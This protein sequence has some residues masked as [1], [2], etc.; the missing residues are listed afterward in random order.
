[1][2][3]KAITIAAG[4]ACASVA[5]V[6]AGTGTSAPTK[7]AAGPTGA[8]CSNPIQIGMEGPF[9]GPVA[10]IGDDQLHWA[11]FFATEWNK[12]HTVKINIV[13][14][15]TQLTPALASTV[16]QSFASNSSIVGVIGPAGSQEVSAA[17]P[18]LKKAGLA[19]ISG[20]ATNP[21]LT[22]GQYTGYFF[23]VVPNDSVQ[24][25]SDADFMMKNL[26]VKKGSTVMVVDDQES[27][28]TGLADIVG[29]K[30]KA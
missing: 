12:T 9:T 20:S 10:S 13:Q 3:R 23:R 2:V 18:I 6:L 5:L 16:S 4:S 29:K 17:A 30:L 27:Y 11:E 19:F 15:D 24:G 22:N 7:A 21:A 8:S 26:G 14:G 1:M 28:S 25:P